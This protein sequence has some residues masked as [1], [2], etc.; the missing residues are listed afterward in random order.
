MF[1][2]L[3]NVVFSILVLSILFIPLVFVAMFIKIDS[4]GPIFFLQERMGKSKKPFVLIK[5]RTMTN[6]PRTPNGEV[7]LDNPEI[8]KVGKFLRRFKVDELPQ[9]INVLKGD[10]S[11]VGPRPCLPA[12][13]EKF[14]NKDTDYRFKVKP[15]VTSNAGV[16][17][18]IFLSWDKKWHYDRIYAENKSFYFDLRIIGK[19]ILV[20]LFGE[21]KFKKD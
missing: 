8:T 16:L 7:H 2:R 17:G 11:V 10:M 21:D 14:K 18:S 9:F 3:F 19:T 5:F 15:G 1:E 13:Y 4:H 20:M 12:T 6:F